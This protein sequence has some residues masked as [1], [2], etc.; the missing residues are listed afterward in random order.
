M[1]FEGDKENSVD[2][3]ALFRLFG[4]RLEKLH[5]LLN[6]AATKTEFSVSCPLKHA[7]GLIRGQ[8]SLQCDH[9]IAVTHPF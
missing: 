4:M 7:C 5:C 8:S 3:W 6:C 1:L 2:P 9:C